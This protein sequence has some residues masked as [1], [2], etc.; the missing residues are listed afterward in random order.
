MSVK[1]SAL[2]FTGISLPGR[3][4]VLK[5][6]I[7]DR[8]TTKAYLKFRIELPERFQKRADHFFSRKRKG[9]EGRLPA[10]KKGDLN[11]LWPIDVCLGVRSSIRNYE[12]GL[13]GA[14]YNL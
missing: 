7:C 1:V 11:F 6:P 5:K 8:L 10:W 13:P 12:C 14:D 4:P 3:W 2:D 9:E